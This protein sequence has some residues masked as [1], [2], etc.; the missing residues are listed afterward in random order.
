V[1]ALDIERILKAVRE[2]VGPREAPV[3]LHEPEFGGNEWAYVKDCIDTGWVSSVGGYVDRFE[4]ELARFLG[5]GRAVVVVNG[6]AALQVCMTL[7]GVE[8]DDEVIIPALTFVA[9]ANAVTYCGAIPHLVDSERRTLGIDP[10]KLEGYLATTAIRRNGHAV[11]RNTGRRI[12]AVVPMHTFGHPVDIA[13]LQAVCGRFDLPM[14]E[15]AAESLGS[16][17]EGRH[18][19]TFG[20]ISALS[21][22]GN[23][24]VTTGGGGAVITNDQRLGDL[25]KHITTTA[26]VPHP[27]AFDHDRVGFN[28]RMPNINAALGCAQL[29]QID[30]FVQAKRELAA[31]YA[32]AFADIEDVEFF[33]EPAHARSNYWLNAV[34]VA[35]RF[36]EERD[37]ILQ[38]AT[39]AGF[40]VRPAWTPMHRLPMFVDSP[41]MDLSVC[42]E[43]AATLINLPSSSSLR[44]RSS[45]REPEQSAALRQ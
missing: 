5:V 22:N 43:I 37:R 24:I 7:A 15:D 41:R 2:V 20:L 25:A 16:L 30:R 3:A 12:A 14:I 17:Y 26:K 18:T 34:M 38:R 42:D 33:A 9:T 45:S 1:T 13:A 35:P 23:K 6:T 40:R 31:A 19:G 21:F 39:E 27:W 36:P 10:A 11:N 8:R 28:Y 4:R 32:R 44:P 29:E